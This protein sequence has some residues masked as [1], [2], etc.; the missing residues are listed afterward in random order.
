MHYTINTQ[1]AK[2]S[3]RPIFTLYLTTYIMCGAPSTISISSG[4]E[5]C[6]KCFMC[7]GRQLP[8]S[9]CGFFYSATHHGTWLP[10]I[11]EKTYCMF[12]PFTQL[13]LSHV[14]PEYHSCRLESETLTQSLASL[15]LP[16]GIDCWCHWRVVLQWLSQLSWHLVGKKFDGSYQHLLVQLSIYLLIN[17]GLLG[18]RKT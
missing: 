12:Y 16:N 8:N 11:C 14:V 17:V 13:F 5:R 10:R 18:L 4:T 6:G 2:A 1:E 7:L 3:K 15:P 9:L